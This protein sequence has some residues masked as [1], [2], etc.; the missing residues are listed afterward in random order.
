MPTQSLPTEESLGRFYAEMIR[1]W[2]RSLERLG[3]KARDILA[4]NP[5][6][7]GPSLLMEA[8]ISGLVEPSEALRLYMSV[9]VLNDPGRLRCNYVPPPMADL[10]T[11]EAVR[12]LR[13]PEFVTRLEEMGR[14]E[15][16]VLAEESR[17][18]GGGTFLSPPLRSWSRARTAG[19][20][21]LNPD[22]FRA[23]R[24]FLAAQPVARWAVDNEAF[25]DWSQ[26]AANATS[27]ALYVVKGLMGRIVEVPGVIDAL[28]MTG[29]GSSIERI[30][31]LMR[32]SAARFGVAHRGCLWVTD[33]SMSVD[34][35]AY[36]M[37]QVD[38][39]F[40][41]FY[42]DSV[43]FGGNDAVGVPDRGQSKDVDQAYVITRDLFCHETR[44]DGSVSYMASMIFRWNT[45]QLFRDRRARM[46]VTVR[47]GRPDYEVPATGQSTVPVSENPF[48]PILDVCQLGVLPFG[49]LNGLAVLFVKTPA[50]LNS[51]RGAR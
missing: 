9:G 29:L 39:T 27:K 36:S 42:Y 47:R 25:S 8:E 23:V 1:A 46:L 48:S 15:E 31:A 6:S 13:D 10:I 21:A 28:V 49:W 51:W 38:A 50:A 17:P 30:E 35:L 5:E 40:A 43:S 3:A 16:A 22:A 26:R 11:R 19:R 37:Q 34:S 44:L 7:D 41:G 45:W 2:A 4:A 12:T 33:K 14:M 18:L 32:E 24:E 20:R